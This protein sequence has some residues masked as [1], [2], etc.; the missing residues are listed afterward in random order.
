M[1]GLYPGVNVRLVDGAVF[2][3][4]G[5][6]SLYHA[7]VDYVLCNEMG[8]YLPDDYNPDTVLLLKNDFDFDIVFKQNFVF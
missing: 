2:D 8:S 4:A 5:L 3:N 7:G 1:K 6:H